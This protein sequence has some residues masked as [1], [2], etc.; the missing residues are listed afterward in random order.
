MGRTQLPDGYGLVIDPCGSI[1]MF[2]MRIPIDV[3]H[4]DKKHRIV[5]ILHSI[6][7]WRVGPIVWKSKYVV[8]L[9]AG[10]VRRTGTEV[11]DT[12]LVEN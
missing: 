3:C 12:V 5:R 10:T 8:E 4:V 2:F 1:H 11:G 7:P 9:P 6:K